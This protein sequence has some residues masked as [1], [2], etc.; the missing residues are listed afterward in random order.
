MKEVLCVYAR[1]DSRQQTRIFNPGRVI[2]KEDDLRPADFSHG[3]LHA[4]EK[5]LRDV[6]RN[7]THLHTWRFEW[8][9]AYEY[10]SSVRK[11]ERNFRR[12]DS[13]HF[14]RIKEN[15]L[16]L[17]RYRLPLRGMHNRVD[18]TWLSSDVVDSRHCRQSAV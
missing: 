11:V 2:W 4:L 15:V 7:Y 8:P 6:V 9:S 14:N 13:R 18:F 1:L 3:A 10:S 12:N 16:T 17:C 5:A